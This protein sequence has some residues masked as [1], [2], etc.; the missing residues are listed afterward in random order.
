MVI[1]PQNMH[2][3]Q[4]QQRTQQQWR[5]QPVPESMT[6]SAS[7]AADESAMV[8]M[9]NQHMPEDERQRQQQQQEQQLQQEDSTFFIGDFTDFA[10]PHANQQQHY[11]QQQLRA[12]SAP[13]TVPDGATTTTDA[14]FKRNSV[15]LLEAC[16]NHDPWKAAEI[17][18]CTDEECAR[19]LV[20]A[21]D[22]FRD[23]ALHLASSHGEV[24][25]VRL[26]LARGADVNAENNL[27]SSPLN[28]AAVA[29]SKE[30]R[31]VVIGI[32]S[33]DI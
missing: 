22:D 33:S 19:Q 3:H 17:L 8:A 10:D 12:P 7:T 9:P 29:G 26:L 25:I 15:Q 16:C 6:S 21:T 20:L 27:G 1:F 13:G 14:W 28:L 23:S 30:V 31:E 2:Q 5:K 32:Y 11:H 18:G 24:D 4:H